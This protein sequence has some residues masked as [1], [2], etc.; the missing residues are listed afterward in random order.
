MLK[1]HG[2]TIPCG[3]GSLGDLEAPNSKGTRQVR[4]LISLM[5][6]L[7]NHP[8]AWGQIKN[9]IA[10]NPCQIFFRTLR[11]ILIVCLINFI[12]HYILPNPSKFL[13]NLK[14]SKHR[15]KY[16]FYFLISI[17]QFKLRINRY[18]MCNTKF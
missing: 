2:W 6:V 17:L 8:I 14:S 10:Q 7:C 9:K 4:G 11:H 15:N 3:G 18:Q 5:R 16:L 1:I 13:F 12:S